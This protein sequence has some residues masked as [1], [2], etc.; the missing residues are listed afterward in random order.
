[1]RSETRILTPS[2][3]TLGAVG[4]DLV[5]EHQSRIVKSNAGAVLFRESLM[6]MMIVISLTIAALAIDHLNDFTARHR[7]SA[8]LLQA[9]HGT[10]G[11]VRALTR[12]S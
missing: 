9:G 7:A 2:A 3:V 4:S 5:R 8:W 6:I 12:D 11:G 10:A 1:M